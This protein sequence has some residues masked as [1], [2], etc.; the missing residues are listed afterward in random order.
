MRV[1]TR[2]NVV[3]Q[4]PAQRTTVAP[5]PARAGGSGANP[6]VAPDAPP[7]FPAIPRG[8]GRVIVDRDGDR[9]VITTTQVPPQMMLMARRA[10]E[11]AFGLMGMLMIIVILGP[12]ARMWARRIEK[13][14]EMNAFGNNASL[15]QQQ[16]VQLQQSVDAMSVEVERI[17]ES[18]RFQSKLL[19]EKRVAEPPTYRSST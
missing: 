18:Q 12:F 9:T 16:L 7:P 15:L 2:N 19:Y 3:N 1:M 5:A 13:K 8:G 4:N 14:S 10:Q 11:T 17:G 6:D